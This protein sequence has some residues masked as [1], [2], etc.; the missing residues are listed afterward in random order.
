MRVT[1]MH[2]PQAGGARRTWADVTRALRRAGYYVTRQS[3]KIEGWE[4]SLE[5]P[6]D[7]VLAV[8][9]DGT[10][11]KV[12]KALAGR[13][14]PMAIIPVGTA[15]NIAR[16]LDIE[17][18]PSS[19]IA[20]LSSSRASRMDLGVVRGPWGSDVFVESVGLGIF[21]HL[22]STAHK[23]TEKALKQS[24]GEGAMIGLGRAR[25]L[26]TLFAYRPRRWQVTID[27]ETIDLEGV[28]L[29]VMNIRSLGPRIVAA[30][31]ADATD[32]WLD[33]VMV[34]ADDAGMLADT[35]LAGS[36]G[37]LRLPP[38]AIRRGRRITIVGEID[39]VHI[40]DEP[41]RL[42]GRRKIDISLHTDAIDL[43]LPYPK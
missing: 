18:T 26:Y 39:A 31:R 23:A 6:T 43:L 17:G 5:R 16:S 34:S 33:V 42:R 27:G 41:R 40:D 25:L 1:V 35:L 4:K 32:A 12:A 24:L 11:A 10:V 19:L 20:R 8:G 21:A 3:T 13:G 14:L 2:N 9:G 29:S 15:N 28:W 36:H 7:L 37:E 30:S 38:R 22:L